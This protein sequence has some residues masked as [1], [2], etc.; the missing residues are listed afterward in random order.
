[1][2]DFHHQLGIR[3]LANRCRGHQPA[4]RGM[5][6]IFLNAIWMLVF[7]LGASGD[8]LLL[9]SFYLDFFFVFGTQA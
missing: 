3:F 9:L 1:M 6:V 5:F 7:L 8:T 4:F 2:G